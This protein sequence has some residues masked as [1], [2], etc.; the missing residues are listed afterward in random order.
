MFFP[1][2]LDSLD[3]LFYKLN[4][5]NLAPYFY[6]F[7]YSDNALSFFYFLK[8]TTGFDWLKFDENWDNWEDWEDYFILFI[9]GWYTNDKCF[10]PER[11]YIKKI[12]VILDIIIQKNY[13]LYYENELY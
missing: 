10:Y 2:Y 13:V 9:N 8:T 4:C 1:N 12:K 5:I 7:L 11:V 3:Y 6:Y